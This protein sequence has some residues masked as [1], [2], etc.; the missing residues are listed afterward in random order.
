MRE[1]Q[2]QVLG[3]PEVELPSTDTLVA[4]LTEGLELEPEPDP[5]LIPEAVR[6]Q[7]DRLEYGA[8]LDMLDEEGVWQRRKLA[9]FNPN[10]NRFLFVD[11][12]GARAEDLG[13]QALAQGLLE[14]RIRIVSHDGRLRSFLDQAL[15]GLRELLGRG[16]N[17]SGAGSEGARHAE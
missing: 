15:T 1:W 14:E 9:W 5:E 17:R 7:I 6:R 12:M 13:L 2:E 16:G 8:L 4:D 10:T 3:N 11:V